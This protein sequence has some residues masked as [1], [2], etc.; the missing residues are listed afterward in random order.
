M[1]IAFASESFRDLMVVLG[2]AGLVIPAFAVLRIS[3][4]VGFILIG[5]VAGPHGLGML[6]GQFPWLAY[7][8]ITDA[9]TL[10]PAA[11]IGIAML[12]F[13]LGLELTVERLRTMRRLVFGLGPVQLVLCALAI[14]IALLPAG[15]PLATV[16]VLALGLALSSTAVG[17]QMLSTS[18][19]LNSR[20][21]R[22]AFGIFL[23]QDIAIAPIL[24]VLNLAVAPG[25]VRLALLRA[26]IAG[27]VI[28]AAGRLALRPLFL[29]AARTRSPELFLAAA[30]VVV[31]GAAAVAAAGGISPVIGALIA[32]CLLADTEYRRQVEAAIAPFGG[33]LLGV[34]LIWVGMRLDLGAVAARPL[35]V[36]GLV[37]VLCLLK[38][39]VVTIVLRLSGKPTGIAAHVALLLAA[40]SE[41]SLIVLGA[42]ATAGFVPPE[43][44]SLALLVTG[45]SLAIAPLLGLAGAA[46]EVRIGSAPRVAP[47][48][49]PVVPGRTIVIGFGRV[50][51][52]V[53]AMLEAHDLAYLA[54][55]S[56]PDAVRRFHTAGKPAVYGDAR[57]HELL[58]GLGLD[59]A[60]AIVV[61]IDAN[62]SLDALVHAI[63]ARYPDLCIVA[64]AR[65]ADHA[66]H[67]YR[68]GVTDAVPETIEASLQLAE[69][70]L[71]DLGVPMGRVIASIHQ[72]RADLR[73]EIQTAAPETVRPIL[74][75]RRL[76]DA[77]R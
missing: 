49:L 46:L 66:A 6:R 54:V 76:R 32:G 37:A 42:A 59:T 2:A 50:G 72:K 27:G 34:F 47:A 11:E 35:L 56:D 43:I 41:T 48:P 39:A 70:A 23:F 3:P 75:R 9:E 60:S 64:R 12:L 44:G 53:A 29:Q 36:G 55:D 63:R 26:V 74:P 33:L 38:A 62:E 19:H 4:V 7:I 14:G 22:T 15:L 51:Q 24:L 45:L 69:A 20:T 52:L 77:V 8:T 16:T 67:L 18:G 30:L 40:P 28:V 68:L 25:G 31:I 57:R 5:I 1:S 10:D 13:G 65:D 73:S 21:G 71:I 17:M 61:T 58:A